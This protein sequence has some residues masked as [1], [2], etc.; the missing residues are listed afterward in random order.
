MIRVRARGRCRAKVEDKGD[1]G[2]SSRPSSPGAIIMRR[3][4]GDF[5]NVGLSSVLSVVLRKKQGMRGLDDGH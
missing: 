5:L 4:S 1:E 3:D 2:K